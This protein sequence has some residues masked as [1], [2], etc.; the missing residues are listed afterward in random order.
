MKPEHCRPYPATLTHP[1]FLVS[2]VHALPGP[3]Y[4]FSK[5]VQSFLRHVVKPRNAGAPSPSRRWDRLFEVPLMYLDLLPNARAPTT[6]P[7]A[8]A[9][10][11]RGRPSGITDLS[12]RLNGIE[13]LLFAIAPRP[14]ASCVVRLSHRQGN[15]CEAKHGSDGLSTNFNPPRLTNEQRMPA[16]KSC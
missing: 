10:P 11:M 14:L 4:K 8:Q 1:S 3:R 5:S 2:L 13:C 6:N 7:S 16:T 12:E 15:A 9:S